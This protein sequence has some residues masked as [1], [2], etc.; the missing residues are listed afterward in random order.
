ML[1]LIL[2]ILF[3]LPKVFDEWHRPVLD[4]Q[5]EKRYL[6][7]D[8]SK[9]ALVCSRKDTGVSQMFTKFTKYQEMIYLI[10]Q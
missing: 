3:E 5:Q 9:L 10:L 2:V 4:S 1:Y 7:L 8:D 6:W